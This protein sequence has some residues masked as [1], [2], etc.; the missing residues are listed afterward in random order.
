MIGGVCVSSRGPPKAKLELGFEDNCSVL[1]WEQSVYLC[2]SH[3]LV[4][5]NTP[6]CSCLLHDHRTGF[7]G[8]WRG[9]SMS[10]AVPLK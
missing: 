5:I 6:H 9:F 4:F 7:V 1:K 10:G 3:L 2:M 8:E